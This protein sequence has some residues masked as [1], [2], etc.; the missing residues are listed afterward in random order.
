MQFTVQ[1]LIDRCEETTI[2]YPQKNGNTSVLN[3]VCERSKYVQHCLR[4][5]LPH[6]ILGLTALYVFLHSTVQNIVI[7]Y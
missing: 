6:L 3:K 1:E 2:I 7:N 5:S 4:V